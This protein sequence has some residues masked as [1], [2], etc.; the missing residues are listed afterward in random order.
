MILE[1]HGIPRIQ[2]WAAFYY[3]KLGSK[4]GTIYGN[5]SNMLKILLWELIQVSKYKMK[6]Y[7]VRG[8]EYAE[9]KSSEMVL[10]A[11]HGLDNLQFSF[12]FSPG[13]P[14]NVYRIII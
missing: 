7:A 14:W 6:H 1:F 5:V 11:C 4:S 12:L 2:I 10:I 13:N 3:T 8:Q 9:Q